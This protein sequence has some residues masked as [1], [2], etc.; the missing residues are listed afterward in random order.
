MDNPI[1]E[2]KLKVFISSAMAV[3]KEPNSNDDF[4]WLDFRKSVKEELNKCPFIQAFI[5]E[6]HTSSIKSNDYMIGQVDFSDIVVLLIKNEFKKGTL[7]EY[8]RCRETNKPLLVFFFGD[9]NAKEEVINLRKDL[10][11]S[12]YCNYRKMPDFINAEKIIAYD[13]IQEIIF[14][15]RYKHHV[16]ADIKPID[17]NGMPVETTFDTDTYVPTK[18]VLS[19]FKTCYRSIYKYIGL[20]QFL[21][22]D[23]AEKKSNL[24]EAG[25]MVINWVINGESFLLPTVKSDL[26]SAVSAIYPNTSWYS[27]RLDAID[28]FIHGNILQ[29]YLSEKDALKLAEETNSA[30]WIINNILIDLRNLQFLCSEDEAKS[31]DEEYQNRLDSLESIVNVP[32]LDRYLEE[33][34]ESL[35]NEE[36]KRNTA[37]V[38]TTFLG[39]GLDNIISGIEN[40]LFVSLLY[41]SYTHLLISRKIFATIFYRTGKLYNS[42]ELLC[43]SVKMYL[44]A[45][46]YKEYI[47][48]S[49][50]EWDNISN[51]IIVNANELWHQAIRIQEKSKNI[52]CI[53][54]LYRVGLYLNDNSFNEAETYLLKL[55][56]DIPWDISDYYIDCLLNNCGRMNQNNVTSIITTIIK[57]RNYASANHLTQLIGS[58]DIE[59]VDENVLTDLCDVMKKGLPEMISRNGDPQCLATLVNAN[60]DIF[61]ILENIPD[62]G[63][64]DNQKLF[65]ELNTGK[66]DWKAIILSMLQ[67][68]ESQFNS[69]SKKGVIYG[70]TINPY[71]V[72]AM[73]FENNPPFDIIEIINEKMFPLCILVLNSNSYLETKDQC[74]EFLCIALGYYRKN[75]IEIPKNLIAC[76]ENVSLKYTSDFSVTYRSYEGLWCRLLTLKIIVGVLDKEVLIQWCF[77]YSQ[78]DAKER[79]ALVQCLKSYLHYSIDI[80]KDVDSLII[81]IVFQCCEDS[82]VYIRM[83]AC[84]CLWYILD[85]NYKETAEEKIYE[86]AIDSAPTI[87]SKL[88][89]ICKEISLSHKELVNKI[90]IGL[91]NDANYM[92]RKQAK[93]LLEA[94]LGMKS[95]N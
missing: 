37:S 80:D 36:I 31:E 94:N 33:T 38:G 61:S 18:T 19:Q 23:S 12:D 90:L 6:E 64:V 91:I 24:H 40:Y 56:S 87:K 39:N 69:N 89:R 42:A 79:R 50:L 71:S 1:I 32:V 83:T 17:I 58:I 66:G 81:S 22:Q 53:G 8:T 35:I 73:I 67:V 28:F 16:N 2:E 34:Y 51:L 84:E 5:I 21:N 29:A 46:M 60:T 25:E 63:L 62:N 95:F 43:S 30:T 10:R 59:S 78:K 26:I 74:A 86:M 7:I 13:V 55:S 44:F 11:N 15:Y 54:I 3:E 82:D 49:N 72:I 93:K 76:I 9:D 57:N 92:I 70:F 14:Y 48:L 88:L 65:Y 20:S 47:R 27:K 68:A 75:G 52:I 45:E 77:S 41:G 85:S 4:K